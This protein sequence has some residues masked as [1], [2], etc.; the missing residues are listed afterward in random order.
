MASSAPDI[1]D[2]VNAMIKAFDTDGHQKACLAAHSLG[3]TFISWM[4]H[5]PV[6]CK[7]VYSTILVDPVT[8]LL[9]DPTVATTVVYKEPSTTMDFLMHFFVARELFIANALSRHFNWSHNIVFVEDLSAVDSHDINAY[10]PDQAHAQSNAILSVCGDNSAHGG[11]N[12][13]QQS[14]SLS[15]QSPSFYQRITRSMLGSDSASN[16]TATAATVAVDK[17]KVE[18]NRFD[19]KAANPYAVDSVPNLQMRHTVG[20]HTC[21]VC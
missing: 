3:N 18:A 15:Q 5:H 8:F 7:R 14:S 13:Q 10:S 2:S 16:A 21:S 9:C 11:D 12:D 4:L 6:A 20:R 1:E 17:A 19:L